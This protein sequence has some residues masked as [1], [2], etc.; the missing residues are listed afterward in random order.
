VDGRG[1]RSARNRRDLLNSCSFVQRWQS[2]EAE[3]IVRRFPR[4]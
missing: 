3:I 4:K 1:S 2:K